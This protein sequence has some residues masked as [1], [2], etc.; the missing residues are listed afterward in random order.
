MNKMEYL[1]KE[2]EVILRILQSQIYNIILNNKA[3]K[4]MGLK[5]KD[6]L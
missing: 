2:E 5:K 4:R 1:N 3:C 6:Y